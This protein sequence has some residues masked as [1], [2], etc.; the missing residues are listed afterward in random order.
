MTKRNIIVAITTFD[1]DALRISLPPLRRFGRNITLVIH[2]DNPNVDLTSRAVRQMGWRDRAHIINSGTNI[3][4]LESRI[5]VVEFIRDN[6]IAGDWIVFVNDDDVLL[7]V[8]VPDISIDTFAVLYNAT[9]LSARFIDLFKISPSW[10]YGTEYGK[11][12]P[13]FDISGTIVRRDIMIEYCDLLRQHIDTI[14]EF[15]NSVKYYPPFGEMMWAGLNAFMRVRHSDMSPIYMDKTNYVAIK[16]GRNTVKY[17]RRPARGAVARAAIRKF[18]DIT[19]YF[20]T[21]NMVACA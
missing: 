20:A 1:I 2:N 18:T 11:T 4:E 19:E 21:Q 13:H 14:Y 10:A 6:N 16:F 5:R 7:G 9:T 3:G 15:T 12:G 17:G 8:D